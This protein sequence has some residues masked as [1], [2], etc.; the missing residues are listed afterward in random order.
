M[1]KLFTCITVL[2]CLLAVPALAEN[3][4]YQNNVLWV[5]T[6]NHA[7]WLYKTG[8]K[9]T[10]TVA[11]YEYGILQDGLQVSYSIGQDELDPDA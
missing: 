7:D 6:P 5:T 9:A 1:K 8:E 4:P 3:Y 10:V 2:F 11:V